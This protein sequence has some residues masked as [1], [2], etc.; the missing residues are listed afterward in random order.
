MP[1][2]TAYRYWRKQIVRLFILSI[3]YKPDSPRAWARCRCDC[4]NIKDILLR[5]IKTGRTKSCGCW[6]AELSAANTFR[7]KHGKSYSSE[8]RIYYGMLRRCKDKKC[9][10]YKNY[11]GRG[12]KICKRWRGKNGFTNF[13]TDMKARP[14]KKYSLERINNDGNYEPTNCKWATRKEQRLNRRNPV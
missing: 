10:A 14:S 1:K 2:H 12:I 13:Y 9:K 5:S 7:L 6:Y 11:G 8:Y 3:F 4:G